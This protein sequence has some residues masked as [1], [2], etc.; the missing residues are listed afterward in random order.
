MVKF[1]YLQLCITS[2]Y[3]KTI[4]CFKHSYDRLEVHPIKNYGAIKIGEQQFKHIENGKEEIGTFKILM[5]WK[6]ENNQWKISKVISYD[7]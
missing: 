1:C 6:Q 7:H 2:V 5:I 4:I 3:L